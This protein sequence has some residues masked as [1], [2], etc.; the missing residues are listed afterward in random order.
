MS[1]EMIGILMFLAMTVMILAGIPL[2]ISMFSCA[3][4]GFYLIGGA[5]VMLSQLT[6]GVMSLAASYNFA[7]VP[8]FMVMGQLAGETGIAEGAFLA[9]KKWLGRSKGGLLDAVVV[10]NM[11]FGACSGVTAAGNVVFS[12]IALPELD[13]QG[14]DRGLAL[15]TITC[16]GTLSVLIPPSMPII[17]FCLLT[18]VSVGAALMTGLATGI[19]FAIVMIA[20]LHV[21]TAIKPSKIPPPDTTKVPVKEKIGTLKL[22]LPIVLL[23]AVI[24]GGSFM[25]WFPATVGGAVAVVVVLIYAVVKRMPAKTILKTIW[26]GLQSFGNIYL[27]VISGQMFGRLVALSGLAGTI[28]DWISNVG[29]APYA[30]FCLVVAFYLFCGMFMDCMSII[31]ITVPIV[32]PVLTGLGYHELLLVMLLVFSM[33]VANLTPPVGLAVFH[34]ANCTGESTSFIFKNVTKFF[35]M[36]LAIILVL[37]LVPDVLLWLPRL[38]GYV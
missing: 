35:I 23:F 14:Y 4:V 20:V 29:L 6:N 19:I 30:V 37:A 25:G 9:A 38:M 27:I 12:R 13:K 34:V 8:L 3:A 26:T 1:P 33:E 5:Q 22:L 16:A 15:G 31:I 28:A 18:S 24:V 36:D 21:Y 11:V 7:V 32:F 17:T 10:A 2:G